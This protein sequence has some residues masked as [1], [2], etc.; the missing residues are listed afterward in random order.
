MNRNKAESKRKIKRSRASSPGNGTGGG[1]IDRWHDT[2]CPYCG[3]GCGLRVGIGDGKVAKVRGNPDHPSSL[4]DLC[5]KPIHLPSAL[6]TPDRIREPLMRMNGMGRKSPSAKGAMGSVT[7]EKATSHIAAELKRIVGEYGPDAVAFYGSG[8]FTTEDYYVANKLLKGFIGTNNFDANSRLCMASAVAGYVSALGSDGPPPA[9]EDIDHADCSFLIGSNM[10]DCHPVLFNRIKRRRK[11]NP[12]DVKVIVVDPRE[13][14]TAAIADLFL[15]VRPGSD[16]VLLNGMMEHIT[17]AGM[18]DRAF[19]DEHTN[20]FEELKEACGRVSTAA[21]AKVCGVSESDLIEAARFFGEANSVLSFWSMG[22]NQSVNGVA[23][24]QAVINL[25]LATGQI[26]KPGSGPFSLTGQ[27]NAMGGREAGGLSHLLPGYRTVTN[28]VHRQEVEQFWGIPEGQIA[29]R[30]G[31]AAV[32]MFEAAARGDIKAMWIMCTN[33]VVSMPNIDVVERAM[34]KLELLIVTDAYHPTDTTQ[35]AHV[36]LPA[37]Q[38]SERD[39][40]MTNSERRITYLPRMVDPVGQ[41]RPDWQI[42][43]GVGAA[44]GFPH[45]FSYDTAEKVFDEFTQLTR[46]RVCDYSGVSVRRLQ[47][48]GPLQWPVPH[49]DHPGTVRLYSGLHVDLSPPPAGM[50]FR[51]GESS[52]VTTSSAGTEDGA[53]VFVTADGRATFNMTEFVPPAELPN[54]K[55]P[56]LLTTGR[57]RNQWHTMTRTGKSESLLKGARQ[58]FLEIHPVDAVRRQIENGDVVEVRSRRGR[59]WAEAR[60]TE[61]IREG[62]CFMPF[63]WGRLAGPYSA[64][65]NVTLAEVDPVSKE[66]ELKACAVEVRLRPGYEAIRASRLFQRI[67]K[68]VK[69]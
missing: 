18:I 22:L 8:Q 39:G 29:E 12:E 44:M 30:P 69:R 17:I 5:L 11:Q 49:D 15:P 63:H 3:V 61:K 27:P 14:R 23:K 36:L 46:G 58:P 6:D 38:W 16:V 4:G 10:A 24:N 25:H 48:E 53:T 50:Q 66:P 37:A 1:Q 41:A 62:A 67:A 55:F 32:D 64:A 43:A 59:V 65:N 54:R 35:Y 26:G 51:N 40:V 19:I 42:I 21:A 57:L 34:E 52:T 60:V 33:P 45:A 28:A 68:A 47:A 20:G 7:W 13:T 56:L 9:Y 31:L 2:Y